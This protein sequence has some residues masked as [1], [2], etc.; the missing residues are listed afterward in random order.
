M[1]LTINAEV[2]NRAKIYA[3]ENG[4][5]LSGM[6][7]KHLVTLTSATKAKTIFD[8]VEEFGLSTINPKAN[9]TELYYKERV[10]KYGF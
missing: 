1:S 2:L 4:E 8:M 5:N 3:E 9:L 10:K 7:E 6:I